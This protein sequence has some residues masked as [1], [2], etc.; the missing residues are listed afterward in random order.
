MRLVADQLGEIIDHLRIGQILA[1]RCGGHDQMVF[2]QPDHQ[3]GIP[4]RQ[5]VTTAELLGIHRAE[6]RMVAATALGNVVIEPGNVDQ[7]WFGQPFDQLA[8]QRIFLGDARLGQLAQVLDDIERVRVDGVDVE[9]VVLHLPDDVAEL[10]QIAAQDAV[11]VHSAKVAVNTFLALEQLDEQAGV[12]QI[13]AEDVIDQ[14]AVI[15]EQAN[16]VRA[17][18]LDVGML[19]EQHE[20]F[21]DRER[22]AFEDSCVAHLKVAVAYLKSAV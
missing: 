14:V 9:Q 16:G 17:N 4:R 15:A 12:A 5:L 7:L 6:F 21:Q 20:G 8:G 22:G 13:L 18:A 19:G 10:R 1:L 3:S 11:A 2:H